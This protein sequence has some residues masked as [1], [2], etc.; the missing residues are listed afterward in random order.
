MSL[1]FNR[2]DTRKPKPLEKP[3]KS[4]NASSVEKSPLQDNN[5]FLKAKDEKPDRSPNI[6]I[7]I[8]YGNELSTKIVLDR[9]SASERTCNWLRYEAERSLNRVDL[10]GRFSTEIKRMVCLKTVPPFLPLDYWLSLPEKTLDALPDKVLLEPVIAP[11]KE[12]TQE[13]NKVQLSDF[14]IYGMI[15]KGA[16]AKVY[17]GN[18][19]FFN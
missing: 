19:F 11:E 8:R 10:D 4:K 15:G 16:F 14:E 7:Q 6:V 17:L 18:N 5:P 2:K 12:E 13:P 1:I 9:R 3:A